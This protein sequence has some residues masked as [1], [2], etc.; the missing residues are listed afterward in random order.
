MGDPFMREIGWK[1][2][3]EAR[4][5]ETLLELLVNIADG[6][7]RSFLMAEAPG[8]YRRYI[9]RQGREMPLRV[10]LGEK[11]ELPF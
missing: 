9:E 6:N 10:F 11:E 5:S 2:R 4:D 1:D 8:A 7:A 3:S